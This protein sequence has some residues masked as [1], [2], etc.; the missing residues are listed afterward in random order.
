MGTIH[1]VHLEPF[2]TSSASHS[3]LIGV[4]VVL[5]IVAAPS[6][7]LG[8][9]ASARADPTNGHVDVALDPGH[10]RWDVG[11]T[12]SGL[13]EFEVTLDLA[14]RA[15]S[16]LEADGFAVRL[17]RDGPER[18]APQV[19][20]DA[21]QAIRVEQEARHQAAGD[22]T[23]FVSI[24]LNGHSN[25]TLRGTETYYNGDNLGEPSFRLA[26]ALQQATRAALGSSGYTPVDRGVSQDLTAGKPYGHFFSLRGPFPSALLEALFLSNPD[27]A[28]LLHSDSIRDAIAQ[29]IANG[30][31]AYLLGDIDD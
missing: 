5:A 10:S 22:A 18:V 23:V 1:G 30:I 29:G 27:E 31:A 28:A 13:R 2:N 4:L 25:T 19:P 20:G 11:A 16:I 14:R 8:R 15:R 6:T 12:G 24:H 9:P 7:G 3:L 26:T 21:T 17:T